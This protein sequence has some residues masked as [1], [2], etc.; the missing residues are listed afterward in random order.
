MADVSRVLLEEMDEY[1]SKSNW[2]VRMCPL[3]IERGSCCHVLIA[4]RRLTPPRPPCVF[5]YLRVAN[6]AVEIQIS[7]RVRPI[8]TSHVFALHDATK[9]HLLHPRQVA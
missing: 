1:L 9:P 2:T 3:H 6:R 8:Q 4:V 7:V 5:E